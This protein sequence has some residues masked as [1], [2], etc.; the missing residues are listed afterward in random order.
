M[1]DVNWANV[2][3]F[4]QIVKNFYQECEA[5]R[6]RTEQEVMQW[7]S[8]HEVYVQG[9]ANFKPI[10]HFLEA[11]IPDYLMSTIQAQKY[12]KPTVIQEQWRPF[13]PTFFRE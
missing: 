10:L 4:V 1:K 8:D 7:R 6:N 12:E 5:V 11:G 3:N 13:L 9:T 2:S